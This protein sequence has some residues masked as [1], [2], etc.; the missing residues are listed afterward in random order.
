MV[1]PLNAAELGGGGKGG[2]GAYVTFKC[3]TN[4]LLYYITRYEMRIFSQVAGNVTLRFL[5]ESDKGTVELPTVSH[6]LGRKKK[7]E[8]QTFYPRM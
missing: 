3:L 5:T 1:F 7:E 8:A 4:S 2:G 6:N